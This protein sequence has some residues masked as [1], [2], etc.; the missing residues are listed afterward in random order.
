MDVTA[1]S[2]TSI[3]RAATVILVS[4]TISA[5]TLKSSISCV[6]LVSS[7]DVLFSLSASVTTKFKTFGSMIASGPPSPI[8]CSVISVIGEDFSSD[9]SFELSLAAE[10]Y[11]ARL[12]F[13]CFVGFCLGI[14]VTTAWICGSALYS[15]LS[16]ACVNDRKNDLYLHLK[17]AKITS[18]T[19]T[20]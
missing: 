12:F 14:S 13:A 3:N 17:T 8:I 10:L 2:V 9:F 1:I 11:F 18:C 7:M 16:C 6:L 19:H 15:N 20:S 5:H 4:Y